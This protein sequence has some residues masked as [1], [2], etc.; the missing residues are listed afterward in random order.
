VTE[1]LKSIERARPNFALLD[2][3]LGS[4]NSIPVG[5]KLFELGVPFIFATGYG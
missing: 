4:E 5:T 2:L 3:N 1:A